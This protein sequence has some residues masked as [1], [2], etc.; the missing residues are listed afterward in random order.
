MKISTTAIMIGDGVP[1]CPFT[2]NA[3]TPAPCIGSD[4]AAW[5]WSR[6]KETNAYQ[7]AVKRYM[8]EHPG[9]TP[10]KALA[11]VYAEH[12]NPE[13]FEHTEGYCG[14]GGKPE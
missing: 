14:L 13:E 12:P 6:A 9:T 2:F 4:C 8:G 5:R 10:A 7:D 3:G 11:A 1:L